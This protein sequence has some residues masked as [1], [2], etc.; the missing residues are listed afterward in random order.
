MGNRDT[1]IGDREFDPFAME[2]SMDGVQDTIDRLYSSLQR[3]GVL[4]GFR[5]IQVFTNVAFSPL[6]FSQPVF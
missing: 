3:R 1:S 6:G 5:S 4:R 2:R